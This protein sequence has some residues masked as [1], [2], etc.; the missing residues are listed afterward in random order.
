M[1]S[2]SGLNHKVA[3]GSWFLRNYE[4]KIDVKCGIQIPLSEVLHL[5]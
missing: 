1:G 5:G 4:I 2:K 3:A